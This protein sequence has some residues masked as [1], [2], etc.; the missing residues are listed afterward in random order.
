ML[1]QLSKLTL[2]VFAGGA[3]VLAAG[4]AEAQDSDFDGDPCADAN[5]CDSDESDSADSGSAVS[6]PMLVPGL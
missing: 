4:T 2:S 1:H 6:R 5:P 3:L